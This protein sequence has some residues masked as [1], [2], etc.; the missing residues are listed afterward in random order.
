MRTIFALFHEIS[1][2]E[3]AVGELLEADYT[4][5]EM[6]AI[7]QEVTVKD[8][9]DISDHKLTA[10]KTEKLGNREVTGLRALFIGQKGITLTDAGRVFASGTIG[11]EMAGLAADKP[12]GG[13]RLAFKLF[14]IQDQFADSYVKGIIAG[15][16][17]FFLKTELNRSGEV[18]RI[19]HDN[20]GEWVLGVP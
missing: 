20:K 6:N 11:M 18:I 12:H 3:T 9:L 14:D 16:I 1:S 10:F 5:L 15:G 13:L 19:L 4:E 17:L 8:Y 7:A 2:A